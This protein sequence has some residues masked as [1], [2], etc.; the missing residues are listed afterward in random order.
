[1][2]LGS[3]VGLEKTA[4]DAARRIS[5]RKLFNRDARHSFVPAVSGNGI[6]SVCLGLYY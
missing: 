6:S 4:R 5:S 3:M 1:M 2:H